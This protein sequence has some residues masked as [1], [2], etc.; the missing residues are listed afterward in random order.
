MLAN[1]LHTNN[2][3]QKM[4]RVVFSIYLV[5]TCLITSLQ[6]LTEYLK[7]QDAISKELKQLE[8]TVRDPV[9]SSLWQYDHSQVDVLAAGLLKI[10]IIEGVDIIN[11]H[12]EILISKRA[13]L[14]SSAPLAMFDTQS[15]LSWM[16][17][18][19]KIY[20]GSL[21]LYSSSQVVL[22]RVLFGFALIAITAIIKLTIFFGL[23]IWAFDR[24]LAVPLKELMIQVDEVQWGQN[25]GK[26]IQLS[27][28]ENNE[29]SE[30]QT[31]INKMLS[32]L[33]K[34][35]KLLLDDEQAKRHWLED[36]VAQRTEALQISNEKLR[37]LARKDS[38]TDILNRGSFFSEAQHL[39]DCALRQNSPATFIL[40]DL[41]Y[42]KV[43]NDTYGHSVGDQVLIHFTQTVQSFLRKTDLFGRIG[44]EEFGIFLPDTGLDDAFS[45]AN[46]ICSEIS[47]SSLTI[48]GKTVSYTVSLGVELS[49]RDDY[50]MA[51]IF[52]RTDV[53]LYGAKN[54][55]RDRVEK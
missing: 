23:F 34:D 7:T 2:L 47:R 10:P 4:M 32:V 9:A 14:S 17:N 29:L 40:M 43:I 39:L 36:A 46:K 5:V 11:T 21:T 49:C 35:R 1:F 18:E 44:G 15:D 33:E 30:L 6:L 20:L 24:Y 22:D 31:H 53:K 13:Y 28:V 8:E 19:Q 3:S 26:R 16:L 38:L 37:N 25:V 41:D 45:L 55:G 54:K 42:F 12:G 27:N 52:K 48:E 51:D 50:S